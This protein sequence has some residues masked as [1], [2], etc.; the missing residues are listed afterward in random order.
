MTENDKSTFWNT[1]LKTFYTLPEHPPLD[2]EHSLVYTFDSSLK[3]YPLQDETTIPLYT[4]GIFFIVYIV[5]WSIIIAQGCKSCTMP[6][7]VGFLVGL[8]ITLFESYFYSMITNVQLLQT[9]NDKT[10]AYIS[11]LPQV[12]SIKI[13]ESIGDINK[14][15]YFNTTGGHGDYKILFNNT[16][17]P[18]S[19]T[20]GY[21]LPAKIFLEKSS[22]GDIQSMNF[23]EYLQGKAY[24][25]HT[26]K[27]DVSKYNPGT[28]SDI[29]FYSSKITRLSKTAYYTSMIIITWAMYI[30][31]SMWGSTRQLYWNL[32]TIML[33][34]ISGA[35]VLTG[36]NIVSYN[37][38][39]YLKKRLLIMAISLGITSILII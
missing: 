13:G 2:A 38:N 8:I 1:L 12:D 10:H 33:A 4:Q 34:V 11:N 23:K 17:L 15:V 25:N 7:I 14:R 16:Y 37:Y 36:Q 21:I 27:T 3:Y 22:S 30:T 29:E 6:Y 35:I 31:N 19:D 20:Y 5:I 39:I 32:L 18:K 9:A 26:T 28:Q 24:K